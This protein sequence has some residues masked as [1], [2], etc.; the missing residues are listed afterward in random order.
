MKW[1]RVIG[2]LWFAWMALFAVQVHAQESLCAVVKIEIAQELTLERQAFEANMRITNSLDT[3]A[4]EQVKINILFEDSDGNSVLA[5][6]DPNS[7]SASFFISLDDYTGINSVESGEN[8][9]LV[10]GKIDPADVAELRWLI[11]PTAGAGG[12]DG[13][14]RLYYVGASL[15]FTYGGESQT[16]EVA[17]DTI[18][19][20]PQPN[21]TLD[22]FLPSEVN[23]DNPFTP[24]IE[25]VEP[26]NLGVRLSNKG[27]GPAHAVKIQSA[28]PKIVENELGLLVDFRITGSFINDSPANKTLLLDFGDIAAKSNVTGRWIMETSLTGRFTEFDATFSHVD[29]YGGAL[30]S[31]I[32]AVN[33]HFLLRDVFVDLPGRDNVRDFLAQDGSQIRVYESEKTGA[34]LPD[35]SDCLEVTSVSGSLSAPVASGSGANRTLT[36]TATAGPVHIR[37]SDPYEGSEPLTAVV[38]GDGKVLSPAN[39]WLSK[40][41]QDDKIHYDYFVNVF[42]TSGG[43]SYTL[44]FG[45]TPAVNQPPVIQHIASYTTYETG[46]VGFLVQASDPDKT[47]PS[48]SASNLPAGATF[49]DKGNGQGVFSWFPQ[50]GQ[51]G[52]YAPEFTA[53]DGQLTAVRAASVTVFPTDDRDGDGMS[54]AWEIEHFGD[55][56]R[57]GTGDFDGDGILD[58]DEFLRESDPTVAQLAPAPPQIAYP[59]FGGEVSSLNPTLRVT[60][61]DHDSHLG[62][63]SY[64]FEVYENESM[65]RKVAVISGVP[66]GVDVTETTISDEL[67][68]N[69]T[70]FWRVNARTLA[71]ASE[72][73]NGRF[74]VNT[75]NDAPAPFT[76]SKP[77][78]LTLVD[79]LTPTLITNNS[80]DADLDTLTYQFQV[81]AE[82]DM[83]FT[84][85][86]AEVRGLAQGEKG[87]TSWTVSTPLENGQLYF[88]VA[89]VTDEHGASTV[90]E[91]AS[92]IVST[93][94]LAPGTGTVVSPVE[95]EVVNG[96]QVS[97]VLNNAVDPERRPLQYWF[98]V[99]E[100]NTFDSPALQVSGPVDE[101]INGT[102]Q[103][104]VTGLTE[105]AVYYWRVK[106]DDGEAQGNWVSSSFRVYSDALPPGVPT[107]DNP[108]DRAWVEVLSPVLSVHPVED[109]NGDS[110]SYEFE[111][112]EDELLASPI[113]SATLDSTGWTP[114]QLLQNH[115][116]YYWRARAVDSTGLVG[117]WSPVQTFFTNKDGIDDAPSLTF[118]LPDTEQSLYGGNVTIQWVDQ[119]PD[120]DAHISLYYNDT[121]L[122]AGELSEDSDGEGDQYSWNIDGL[123]AGSYLISA[124]IRDA[125]SEVRTEACCLI[126]KHEREM[127]AS[128]RAV[129]EAVT[130]EYGVLEATFEV[131]LDDAPRAG[132]SVLLNLS[133]SDAGEGEIVG[134]QRYLEFTSENWSVPQI[135]K[136]R[137]RDDCLVDGNTAFYLQF[138]PAISSDP[139][140]DGTLTP[141]V[142]IINRDNETDDQTLFICNYQLQSQHPNQNH[143]VYTYTARLENQGLGISSAIA[144]GRSVAEELT[145]ESGSTLEFPAIAQGASAWSEGVFSVSV[146]AGTSPNLS[147]LVWSVEAKA[148]TI[149]SN[150]PGSA[151]DSAEYT[152][153][154]R[155]SGQPGDS[156]TFSLI[157]APD[158]MSIDP[159]TG[160]IQ[161][162]PSISQLGRHEVIVEV[163]DQLG[164]V[165]RQTF[166]V[167][168]SPN[169][170]VARVYTVD[171]SPDATAD[172]QSIG[173][174]VADLPATFVRPIVIHAQSDS[175]AMDTTPVRITGLVTTRDKGLSIVLASGYQLQVDASED[176]AR[177]ITV[178]VPHVRITGEGGTISVR[179]NGFNDVAAIE[180]KGDAEEEIAEIYLDQLR[181]K[182]DITGNP[183]SVYGVI[184]RNPL[185]TFVIRNNEISGFRAQSQGY[186]LW[187]SGKVY[188][189]NNTLVDNGAG[190][191]FEDAS[192]SIW[193]N[194]AAG[195][196]RDYLVLSGEWPSGG[197]NLSS[198][199]SSPQETFG[200]REVSFV[201]ASEG[202]YALAPWDEAAVGQG[203]DLSDVSLYPFANDIRLETRQTP[204]DIGA[205]TVG[206]VFNWPPFINSD[207]VTLVEQGDRYEYAVIASDNDGDPLEYALSTA[208]QGMSI[209]SDSG[210]IQW[211]PGESQVGNYS[212]VVEVSDGRGGIAQQPF[213]LVVSPSGSNGARLVTV[214]TDPAAGAD[215]T[216]LQDAIT[217]EAGDLAHPI[218]IRAQASTGLPDTTPVVIDGYNTNADTRISIVLDQGYSLEID[219]VQDGIYGI[220]IRDNHVTLSSTG[221]EILIRNNGYND[222]GGVIVEQQEPGSVIILDALRVEGQISGDPAKG[223]GIEAI[224][225]NATYVLRNNIVS[226]FTGSYV[227]HG[228]HT[229]GPAFIY[230]NTLAGN[231]LGLRVE[232]S[233]SLV[234]N[235]LSTD[236]QTD[237]ISWA[238]AWNVT[239]NNLSSDESSPDAGFRSRRVAFIDSANGNYALAPWDTAALGQGRDLSAVEN[240]PFTIDATGAPRQS[241]WDLGALMSGQVTNWPPFINSTPVTQAKQGEPY[242]YQVEADDHDG[243]PLS[244]SLGAGPEG[245]TIDGSGLLKWTPAQDQSG[246][247][248]VVVLVEDGFGGEDQQ[249]FTIHVEA[250]DEEPE[251]GFGWGDFWEQL[252][253]LLKKLLSK[254]S[255][256]SSSF[257]SN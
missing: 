40:T 191:V 223:G 82:D 208:P 197:N 132:T 194:L 257:M 213:G 42:D 142:E 152:Y 158:G 164:G 143:V 28:Q 222:V 182:G 176:G 64:T 6:S 38:R 68:D 1:T 80:V 49:T 131:V 115:T 35:C 218:L 54:D 117:D 233:D 178:E 201:D 125:N 89:V 177:A 126:H 149:I 83:D 107:L 146:P 185:L 57:D 37:V 227:N 114:S 66:E 39:Y 224:D 231:R 47:T 71:G 32:E 198:D 93:S 237:Y 230:N 43:S 225:P 51:A 63:V 251:D 87:Q 199:D 236:N 193:N 195:N 156:F 253:E 60:N 113:A 95:G 159:V 5:S 27:S 249:N 137:G 73:V 235:N 22:Y 100:V 220:R 206:E 109:A 17:P 214:N 138:S 255:W 104:T 111:L 19:V 140:F 53:S 254:L 46:Q 88:W 161:W 141:A 31:L 189:Y 204:W 81:F 136:V 129:S 24:E 12:D 226:G 79:T 72:W 175:G 62:S 250:A 196:G 50:V 121:N 183:D 97:L 56:S 163:V 234:F 139:S 105:G 4:L 13:A 124:V 246:D 174:A 29:E 67:K 240:Y 23:G 172:F 210:V 184:A 155:A 59:L 14:G 7:D 52:T 229:Q 135:V 120:S 36:T 116:H 145:L 21:L 84:N 243:D 20:K 18:V 69:T 247:F 130:D 15:S 202:N 102:I 151:M 188:A 101:G 127:A 216:S 157:S 30:T 106:A 3:M 44:T 211:T 75:A 25:P 76:V 70:Y 110:V 65:T 99:D 118:V 248:E 78:D 244:Y 153:Q 45:G 239:G 41:I 217:A 103:W 170:S 92:F 232:H 147:A 168:V 207:P 134:E 91:A 241:P 209:D 219:A 160:L 122:I 203:K 242:T 173:E 85:P 166:S 11:V 181:V 256:F 144:E 96:P 238:N 58:K 8:G 167:D 148:P 26:Y 98:E 123:P 128:V 190:L 212:V 2:S 86:V 48:L 180:L 108:A 169:G 112:Y 119:D 74:F 221:G 205:H 9:A 16:I 187:L 186:G 179:N 10:D 94:N 162:T 90:S 133:V 215:Y 165:S 228:V 154:V 245:M 33:T 200:S 150:A 171:P 55:L 252:S 61:G 77:A 34:D 192:G